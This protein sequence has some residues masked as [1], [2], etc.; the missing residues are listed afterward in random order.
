M[1][2][3]DILK[4]LSAGRTVRGAIELPDYMISAKI[5]FDGKRQVTIELDELSLDE[6]ISFELTS[7]GRQAA[8]ESQPDD[9]PC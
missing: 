6:P 7:E 5:S 1:P 2:L 4:E 3:I 8:E 9:F